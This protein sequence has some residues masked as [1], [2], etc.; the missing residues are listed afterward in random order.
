MLPFLK[1]IYISIGN[2]F[3]G[4]VVG[5]M[6]EVMRNPFGKHKQEILQEVHVDNPHPLPG[7]PQL[8]KFF[9]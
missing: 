2:I 3:T 8:L 5:G 4:A 9:F 1:G 6:D 7:T